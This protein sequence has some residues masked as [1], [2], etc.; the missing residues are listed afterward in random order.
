MAPAVLSRAGGEIREFFLLER[1]QRA[2]STLTDSQQKSIELYCSAAVRRCSVARRLVDSDERHVALSLYSSAA[3]LLTI[4]FLIS[5][6]AGI[7][8]EALT[9]DKAFEKFDRVLEDEKRRAP[10]E[11]GLCRR[12]WLAWDPLTIE[13]LSTEEAVCSITE[14][15]VATEWLKTLVEPR[16]QRTLKKT[17]RVRLSAAALSA[18]GLAVWFAASMISPK[19]VA[20]NKPAKSSSTD[21]DT[22]PAGA[23]DGEKDG[24]F[25]FHSLRAGEDS[26]W[27]SID[28]GRLYDITKIKVFG[29]G[30]CCFELSV[31]LALE[32]SDDGVS[33]R[34]VAQRPEPFSEYDPWL[35]NPA[36]L[37]TRF[38]RLRNEHH[39]WLVLSEVEVYG[40]PKK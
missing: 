17:R 30:D 37:V 9:P 28:L 22:S 24:R 7:D 38:V 15:E 19:N 2:H 14:F 5:R 12:L 32:V 23:V 1:A 10:P 13:K 20:L 39:G 31:P 40:K 18:V 34:T 11:L 36:P 35:I 16:S 29:R 8:V 26:P 25:G 6:D 3:L 4:A 27:L 33:F 21:F